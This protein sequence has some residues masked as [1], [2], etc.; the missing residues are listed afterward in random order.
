VLASEFKLARVR[1]GFSQRD[2]ANRA[3]V[4]RVLVS[5]CDRGATP[6]LKIRQRLS[7]ALAVDPEVLFPTLS[8]RDEEKVAA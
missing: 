5:Y 4:S 2:L 3:E 7:E 8:E 6:G 1:A